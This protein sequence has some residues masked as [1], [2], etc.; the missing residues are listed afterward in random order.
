MDSIGRKRA[1]STESLVFGLTV[2]N[3]SQPA[4]HRRKDFS[5]QRS[6]AAAAHTRKI[7]EA[8]RI[9]EGTKPGSAENPMIKPCV[10]IRLV[11]R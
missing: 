5:V 8:A 9:E 1:N 2:I 4:I 10:A 7:K 3:S 11:Q 6:D